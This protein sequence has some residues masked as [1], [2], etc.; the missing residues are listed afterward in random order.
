MVGPERWV[1]ID[2]ELGLE[3]HFPG[4]LVFFP[5]MVTISVPFTRLARDSEDLNAQLSK[6]GHLCSKSGK[7]HDAV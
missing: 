7:G 6:V 3:S 4:C 2:A 5:Q 1:G